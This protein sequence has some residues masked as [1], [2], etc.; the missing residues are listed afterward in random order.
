[1][2]ANEHSTLQPAIQQAIASAKSTAAKKKRKKKRE[3]RLNIESDLPIFQG[4][5]AAEQ[6]EQEGAVHEHDFG[7]ITIFWF[8]FCPIALSSDSSTPRCNGGSPNLQ[9]CLRRCWRWQ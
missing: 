3:R 8:L 4:R 6:R 5:G 2:D 7:L 9:H 1:V